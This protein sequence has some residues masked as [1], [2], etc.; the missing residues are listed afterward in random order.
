MHA[1]TWTQIIIQCNVLWWCNAI[2]TQRSYRT[3]WFPDSTNIE[4]KQKFCGLLFF[5]FP[6]FS[7]VFNCL[8]NTIKSKFYYL[9]RNS[10]F[11][12]VFVFALQTDLYRACSNLTSW[13]IKYSELEKINRLYILDR[14][15]PHVEID[16]CKV[17]ADECNY[18]FLSIQLSCLKFLHSINNW[19]TKNAVLSHFYLA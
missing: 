16:T 13:N 8:W 7:L 10:C 11:N 9:T 3:R 18:T 15:D 17:L 6:S 14:S 12:M 4:S 2:T 5:L 1:S 19:R